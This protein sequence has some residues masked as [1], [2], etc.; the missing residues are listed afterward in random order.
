VDRGCKLEKDYC[1]SRV[2]LCVNL[3]AQKITESKGLFTRTVILTVSDATAASDTAQ[4][5]GFFLSFV[6]C[7]IRLSHL[8]HGAL[9]RLSNLTTVTDFDEFEVWTCKRLKRWAASF[10]CS[11]HRNQVKLQFLLSQFF[12]YDTFW[13]AQ[14]ARRCR[15]R[16]HTSRSRI[17][18][19]FGRRNFFYSSWSNSYFSADA[20]L[21]PCRVQVTKIS[22][23]CFL[24]KN[25]FLLWKT[26]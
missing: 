22:L 20:L 25:I 5:I 15:H 12:S 14:V 16:N 19:F 4:K 23:A 24:N 3:A 2:E 7:R 8:T 13:T 10:K 9:V 26:T 17:V 6:R 11:N 18:S 1:F 21:Y